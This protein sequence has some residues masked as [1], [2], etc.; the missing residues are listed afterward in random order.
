MAAKPIEQHRP[1]SVRES[2]KKHLFRSHGACLDSAIMEKA[3]PL[4]LLLLSFC[5]ASALAACSDPGTSDGTG[6]TSSGGT[7]SGGASSG[8]ASTGGGSGDPTVP[9]DTS[10]AGIEAFLAAG[11]YRNAPWVGDAAP[12]PMVGSTSPHGDVQVFSNPAAISSRSDGQNDY[13]DDPGNAVGS[14]AVKELY[15]VGGAL[16]GHAVML[17]TAVSGPSNTNPND[18]LYYCKSST[19]TCTGQTESGPT[20]GQGAMDCRVCHGGT[21]LSP[22]PP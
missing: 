13:G 21:F 11:S 12:R 9:T 4:S 1:H 14:M 17:R 7:S 15:S 18:W 3:L 10:Q 16:Q 22:V 19:S 2:E 20:Y 5:G 6:G 8:G